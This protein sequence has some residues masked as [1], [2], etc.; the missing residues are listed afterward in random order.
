[1]Y[2]VSRD[3]SRHFSRFKC[4]QCVIFTSMEETDWFW[5]FYRAINSPHSHGPLH[6]CDC[7]AIEVRLLAMFLPEPTSMIFPVEE[8]VSQVELI[9]SISLVIYSFKFK[10]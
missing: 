2:G 5:S 7:V 1:M 4:Y 8:T 9:E 10:I 3:F 6:F